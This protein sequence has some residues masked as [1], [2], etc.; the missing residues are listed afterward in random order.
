MVVNVCYIHIPRYLKCAQFL[1]Q[2]ICIFFQ[3]PERRTSPHSPSQTLD[4]IFNTANIPSPYSP[5]SLDK[6]YSISPSLVRE[7]EGTS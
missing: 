3:H 7:A 2:G 6:E 1:L 5:P 4:I